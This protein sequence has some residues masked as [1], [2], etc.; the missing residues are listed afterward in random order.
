MAQT[1]AVIRGNI[2]TVISGGTLSY[3]VSSTG[4]GAPRKR[5]LST[6]GPFQQGETFYAFRYEK[7][8][9]S[10][11]FYAESTSLALADV[12]R[13]SIYNL[14]KGIEGE[15]ITIKVTRD[16]GAVRL[17]DGEVI[18]MIDFP[19]S[20]QDR[21]AAAQSFAVQ[22]ECHGP[23]WRK[24]TATVVPL[25]INTT[26]SVP[27]N[28]QV[29][30]EPI[31]NIIGPITNPVLTQVATGKKFDFTGITIPSSGNYKID[32]RY[33]FKTVLD[34]NL[35]NKIADLTSDSDL[36]D[37]T[38]DKFPNQ[39][40][41]IWES[42]SASEANPWNSIAYGNGVWIA[43]AS[44]GTNRVMR[45]VNNG[46]TWNAISVASDSWMTIA[47]GNGVW[48]AITGGG[49]S[50]GVM[51]STDDGVTWT[52]VT[53]PVNVFVSGKAALGYG[54]GVWIAM[55]R[56]YTI[57]STDNGVTW[58]SFSVP[59]A[60]SSAV[61][62]AYNNG[63]WVSVTS[64]T[65]INQVLRSTN[66]GVTWSSVSAPAQNWW[67]SIAYGNGVWIAVASFGTN[68]VMRS[69]DNGVTWS[70]VAAA[71]QNQWQSIAYENGIWAAVSSD[72]TNRV[73]RSTDNGVTWSSVAAAEQNQWQYVVS[74]NGVWIAVASSGT[75]RV[76][77]SIDFAQDHIL[78]GTGTNANTAITMTF[79]EL[80]LG[81]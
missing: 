19:E 63:V 60:P 39:T 66:D 76:M 35:A 68:R 52:T 40:T 69:T 65:G 6:R 1:W 4:I 48:I 8:I 50:T 25:T 18:N 32:T 49:G 47:Y 45:S 22:V 64:D 27:Y 29:P 79:N 20:I 57:R 2:E 77:R 15:T 24:Q 7:R 53:T 55:M 26:T 54:N 13:D 46:A 61:S 44:S 80:Y 30:A 59:I 36:A 9:M 73:M 67:N 12:R 43:V 75:N 81:I 71:E 23:F 3:R 74:G 42:K 70:S 38:I 41:I 5:N 31:I 62:V 37:F 58:S 17:I 34:G 11:V 10:L 28:G 78:T 56:P 21:F 33:G 16:D 72:G 14:W 51:R